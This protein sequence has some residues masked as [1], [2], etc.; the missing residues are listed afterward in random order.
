[1]CYASVLCKR[2][3]IK[4]DRTLVP[5][6]VTELIRILIFVLNVQRV[7]TH[8]NSGHD[9]RGMPYEVLL[10]CVR[11]VIAACNKQLLL[12]VWCI[13]GKT[14]RYRGVS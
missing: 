3:G 13:A 2:G 10:I 11:D 5:H 1:M 8:E 4:G 12:L 6:H 14:Y 7:L 9:V